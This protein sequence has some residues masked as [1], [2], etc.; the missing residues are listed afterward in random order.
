MNVFVFAFVIL[1]NLFACKQPKQTPKVVEQPPVLEVDEQ[2]VVGAEQLDEYLPMLEGKRVAV[3][4]NQTSV[5]SS[6]HLVD[7]LLSKQ[8]DIKK[9]FAPEHGFRGTADAG[10]HIKNGVDQSTGLP[11]ISLYGKHK[12]PSREQLADIDIVIFDIQDVGARFY[13]Y[14]SSLEYLMEACAEQGKALMILDRPNPN[15]HYVDGPILNKQ[16]KSFVGMQAIPVVHGMTV[17]EYAKYLNGEQLLANQ[18]QANLILVHCKNYTHSKAY[19]VPIPPS[20]NLPNQQSILL[21]PSLCFFEGTDISVGRGTELQFQVIGSP[22]WKIN[23]YSFTPV[24]KPGATSPKFQNEQCFGKN[25]QEVAIPY[26]S[27]QLNLS[28]LLEAYQYYQQNGYTFFT[29]ASFFDKL[30]GS[31]ELRKQIE[32]GMSEEQIRATWQPSLQQFKFTRKQYLL[33]PDFE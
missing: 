17:A 23:S 7:V 16:Y 5:V 31:D 14:I 2:V 12:K 15:G 11:I 18:V 19:T 32:S 9:V 21:Y 22:K 26:Q 13:T 3:M 20:P 8:V 27:E 33:Y 4:V 25:L 30:A 1:F 29:R 28:Y 10:E 6:E 24:S